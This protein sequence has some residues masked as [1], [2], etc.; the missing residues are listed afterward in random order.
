M[1]VYDCRT[2]DDCEVS[3]TSDVWKGPF[4]ET[5]KYGEPTGAK[6]YRC[7]SCGREVLE[8]IDREHVA[9]RDGCRFED[10]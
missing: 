10:N 8:G 5:D 4:L 2:Q 3:E 9:H 7:R 1:S 6:Y